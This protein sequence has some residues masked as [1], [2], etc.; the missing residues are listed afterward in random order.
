MNKILKQTQM[1]GEHSNLLLA[2]KGC[3]LQVTAL[4]ERNFKN[5]LQCEMDEPDI[6]SVSFSFSCLALLCIIKPIGANIT[7]VLAQLLIYKQA[8][9][10]RKLSLY[11]ALILLSLFTIRSLQ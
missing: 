9:L 1:P 8:L 2:F 6:F 4:E 3:H 11:F 10:T 5:R 7:C